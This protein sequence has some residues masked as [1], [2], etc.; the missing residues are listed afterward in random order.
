MNYR[1]SIQLRTFCAILWML[2]P[3]AWPAHPARAALLDD[4]HWQA[5]DQQ[6]VPLGAV[7]DN[8]GH[9]GALLNHTQAKVRC[10]IDLG[11]VTTVHRIY[12]T[13]TPAELGPTGQAPELTGSRY[14]RVTLSAGANPTPTGPVL[15]SRDVRS[16]TGR[17]IRVEANLRFPPV[18][19]RYLALDLDRGTALNNRWNLGE[20]EVYGWSGNRLEARNDAVVLQQPA[21]DPLQLAAQ[22]LSYY[23]GELSD[24]PVPVITPN[25]SSSYTGT[26][27]KLVDLKELAPTYAAMTNHQAQGLFPVTPVN[28]ERHGREIV[29]RAWPYRNVLWSV[30]EFL[31]R[32]G[33]KFVFPDAHGDYV[34][35]G[36][37]IDLDVAPFQ[38]TPSTDFI[39]ANFGVEYLRDDPDAFLHFWRNRWTTTWGGHQRDAFGGT[40]VPARPLP[41]YTP[42]PDYVEGFDGYPHNFRNVVPDRLLD[43][44]PAWCGILTNQQW[45][46]WVGADKLNRRLPVNQNNCTFDMT[47]PELR[48]FVI[49]KAISSWNGHLPW[50]GPVY[51]LLPD[52]S[53]L[54][55]EDP[56]SV[57]LRAP[58]REDYLP[59][60]FP[61]SHTV[62]GD[63]YDFIIA[64]ADGIREAL[65]E[66]KVGAMAYSNTHEPPVRTQPFPDNVVVDVCVYGARNL[67]MSSPKNTAMRERLETWSGL[68]N[69]LRHYDYDLIH[70]ETGP[71]RMPVPMISAFADR[72]RF[73]D[74]N[75][76]LAGGTQADLDTLPYNPWNYYAYPRFHWNVGL[77]A[78]TV[79][80]EF[81]TGYFREA[82]SPMQNYYTTVERYLIANHVSLQARGYDYG[83]RVGAYPINVLRKMHQH[84]LAAE[85]LATYWV[86]R[87][88]IQKIREGFQWIMDQ[89]ELSLNDLTSATA[90][91]SVT[92]TQPFTLDLGEA[93]IQTGGQDV[94]DAWFMYSWAQVGDF[95]RI[96]SPGRYEVTFR[97]GMWDADSRPHHRREMMFYIGAMS[98]GPFKIDHV[99]IDTYTLLVDI[100]AGV[101]EVAVED[102]NN[103]GPYRVYPI[104]LRKMETPLAP[105]PQ[106]MMMSR[107]YD[108]AAQGN[109]A[110]S[111]DSDWDG[112]SDL[113]ELLA[114]TDELDPASF[115]AACGFSPTSQGLCLNWP[116]VEGK[117]YA[118]YR[119]SEICGAYTLVA[120][121][122]EATPPENAY[123]D[124]NAGDE[125]AFYQIAAY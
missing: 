27:F 13:A 20:I 3:W 76:M 110:D 43:Q 50:N 23:L 93:R 75:H 47:N 63:Y 123:T 108:F 48:Q 106:R 62:S 32:Q 60:A 46:S 44:H 56:A 49:N 90:F 7:R 88:R 19:A 77:N 38:Y 14:F 103:D 17:E 116:S 84:L 96:S 109:P 35:A 95:V 16:V 51:W 65:P 73:Y 118:L 97:A 54:F 107:V 52:D 104:T 115:F 71:L 80:Q 21:P 121:N 29:F 99:S 86:T 31:D 41:P 10:L 9:T 11:T 124:A 55:S 25:Q 119:A 1:P 125:A 28:V 58:L 101:F 79:R 98:Y 64:V 70:C 22:E 82:A 85:G 113:H 53:I 30:W 39:Y 78:D 37:G 26:L 87:E 15:V 66:A 8:D 33:V 117:R 61:Y 81:F 72:A 122:L 102:L 59:Y 57:A 83:L 5:A 74:R 92:P 4:S 42:P 112:A 91:P 89:R 18:A 36:R 67:P 94:G 105:T 2:S 100:P 114:G 34:P 69:N 24:R 6:D 68:V 120:D 12:F 40:E 111:I 45:A